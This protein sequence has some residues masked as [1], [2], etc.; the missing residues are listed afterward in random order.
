VWQRASLFSRGFFIVRAPEGWMLD[1]WHRRILMVA[2]AAALMSAA[3][4]VFVASSPTAR[5][6]TRVAA[7]AVVQNG[8]QSDAQNSS[9][10]A[11][12]HR[13]PG[14][15]IVTDE[16]GRR[17]EISTDVKRIVTLAPNLTETVY[18]L[19]LEDLLVADTKYC[20]TPPAAK[21]KAHVGDP[22]NPSLES[23]VALQPDLVLATTS[24]NRVETADALKQLGFAVYTTDPQTVRGML[25]S[26]IH[27][28]QAMGAEKQGTQLVARMQQ[29]LDAVQSRL[30]D[31]PMV[32]V[33]FVVWD[34]PLM[35]IGQNTFIADALRWAGAE[36]VVL[37]EQKWPR[38]SLEEVVRLQPDYLVFTSDHGPVA[39]TLRDLRARP[40]WRDL[41]AVETGHVVNMSEEAVRP[42]PGLVD[43]IEQLAHDV[44]PEAFAEKSETGNVK[45]ETRALPAR[46]GKIGEECGQ[47][48]R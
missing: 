27:M 43:A 44:H 9:Q 29:R 19:G 10:F 1:A 7:R 20:D 35:T 15:R 32:H 3:P 2:T 30:H 26:V 8:A 42:S 33:L 45:L 11:S 36:S 39:T 40:G 48:A 38:L 37:S 16:V 22:Q 6:G 21:L 46:V 25:D 47:C 13:V 4:G 28:A 12:D 24:I 18:A 17:V 34:Q 31:R 5:A 23:I 41:D 14:S